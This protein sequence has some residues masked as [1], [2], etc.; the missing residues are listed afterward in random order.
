LALISSPTAAFESSTHIH[1]A[2]L[3]SVSA[4]ATEE[5]P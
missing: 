2:T 3:P 1:E 5:P 4:S